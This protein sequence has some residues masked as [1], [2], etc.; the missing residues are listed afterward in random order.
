MTATEDV[1]KLEVW[2]GR[3]DDCAIAFI[4][5]YTRIFNFVRVMTLIYFIPTYSIKLI[6]FFI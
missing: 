6:S 5:T 2:V 1:E 4:R 3:T